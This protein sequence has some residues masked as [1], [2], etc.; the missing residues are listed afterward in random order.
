MRNVSSD[1]LVYLPSILEKLQQVFPDVTIALTYRDSWEL[2]VAVIL[3]AQC[4][5]VT[6]NKV[7]PRLFNEAKT[8]A[9]FVQMPQAALENLIHATGFYRA[10]AANIKKAAE[11]IVNEFDGVVP[12]TMEELL[13]LPG[14]ARKTANVLLQV[15]YNKVEG[16]VVDTHVKRISQR[17]RLVDLAKISGKKKIFVS[18]EGK[19]I[20]DYI[21]DA[22]PVKIENELMHVIPKTHWKSLSFQLISLGRTSCK[23]RAPL[24]TG[25][26]LYAYCP[27][28]RNSD[29]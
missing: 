21:D 13:R 10:K 20:V 3:S 14:V 6:V 5:D 28:R 7:T 18:I 12:Q 23:A 4:T 2:L 27:T 11:I 16:I 9:D 29:H 1:E 26:P 25:C 22:D 19:S 17:L 8:V 15:I 24:C